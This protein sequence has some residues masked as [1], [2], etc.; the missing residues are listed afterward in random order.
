MVDDYMDIT[1]STAAST[2]CTDI[3]M[4]TRRIGSLDVMYGEYLD[5]TLWENRV[6][7][8]M[9][10]LLARADAAGRFVIK[11][12]EDHFCVKM[13]LGTSPEIYL[14]APWAQVRFENVCC[15][16]YR[17]PLTGDVF[18]PVYLPGGRPLHTID[19]VTSCSNLDVSE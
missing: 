5:L 9:P 17:K 16:H 7:A 2:Y 3:Y 13:E 15:T 8:Q 10:M 6:K 14:S 11:G 1:K 19:M 12:V 18:Q 4:L